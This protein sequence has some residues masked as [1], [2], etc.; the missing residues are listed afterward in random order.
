MRV[1]GFRPTSYSD[2]HKEIVKS[3]NRLS[4]DNI[5]IL[6]SAHKRDVLSKLNPEDDEGQEED[7]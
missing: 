1:G 6:G 3:M 4:A 7:K 2:S 5:R